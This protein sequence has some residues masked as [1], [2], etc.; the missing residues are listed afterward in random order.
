VLKRLDPTK[1]HYTGTGPSPIPKLRS[2]GFSIQ[3]FHHRMYQEG[4]NLRKENP[5]AKKKKGK[6]K[7]KKKKKK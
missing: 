1:A 4:Q 6:K 3:F 7:G 2:S 5:V